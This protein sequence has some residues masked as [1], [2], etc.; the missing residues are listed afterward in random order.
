VIRSLARLEATPGRIAKH[1][2][3]NPPKAGNPP[4]SVQGAGGDGATTPWPPR[5]SDPY[6]GRLSPPA[7]RL[8]THTF[9]GSASLPTPSSAHR[10]ATPPGAVR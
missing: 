5:A 1:W 9:F 10:R 8:N 4:E 3:W 2:V 7:S 6:Q